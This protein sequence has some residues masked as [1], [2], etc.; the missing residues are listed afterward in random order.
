MIGRAPSEIVPTTT[1]ASEIVP[2]TK[3][4]SEIGIVD[5]LSVKVFPTTPAYCHRIFAIGPESVIGIV[6][7]YPLEYSCSRVRVVAV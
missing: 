7:D 4:A 2:A 3:P 6:V 1:P 5:C